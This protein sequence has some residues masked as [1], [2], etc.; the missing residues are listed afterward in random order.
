MSK[1]EKHMSITYPPEMLPTPD[2]GEKAEVV[3]VCPWC[4]ANAVV[5]ASRHEGPHSTWC[6][7]FRESQRGGGADGQSAARS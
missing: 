1:D 4:G 5:N 7:H 3:V 6:V 2:E